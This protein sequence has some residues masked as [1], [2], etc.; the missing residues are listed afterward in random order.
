MAR[1][2]ALA[3]G[4]LPT[5]V[6]A[7]FSGDVSHKN[8][9]DTLA[10]NLSRKGSSARSSHASIVFEVCVDS[11]L[12]T[13]AIGAVPFILLWQGSLVHVGVV[14]GP[15]SFPFLGVAVLLIVAQLAEVVV[16]P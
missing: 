6:A 7:S 5:K 14:Q 9:R 16:I 11:G 4:A 13:W 10:R 1:W 3:T 15:H 2:V 8:L 12:E